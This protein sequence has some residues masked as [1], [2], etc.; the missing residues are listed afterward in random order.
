MQPLQKIFGLGL[1]YML[2]DTEFR[3]TEQ[4]LGP[5]IGQYAETIGDAIIKID[6]HLLFLVDTT[7]NMIQIETIDV[8]SLYKCNIIIGPDFR[9]IIV[10]HHFILLPHKHIL[11]T[12]IKYDIIKQEFYFDMFASNTQ[13]NKR[14]HALQKRYVPKIS[15]EVFE[16]MKNDIQNSTLLQEKIELIK[17]YIVW[18]CNESIDCDLLCIRLKI[19]KSIS[20]YLNDKPIID[21]TKLKGDRKDNVGINKESNCV[22]KDVY[23]FVMEKVKSIVAEKKIL[24]NKNYTVIATTINLLKNNIIHE[25]GSGDD[26]KHAES[27]LINIHHRNN[28]MMNGFKT[29]DII[30]VIRLYNNGTIGSGLPCQRCVKLIHMNGINHVVF[31]IDKNNYKILDMD[32]KTYTYTTT[33]NKLLHIDTYLYD[34]YVVHKACRRQREA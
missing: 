7:E 17:N 8:A 34:E 32:K 27:M 24:E 25:K 29:D 12:V 33:G 21:D 19:Q 18:T 30:F 16:M 3:K 31:S 23:R 15:D 28:D 26:N 20:C 14:I 9:A 22:N 13:Y 4:K 6:K 10:N 2:I 11:Y 1:S 5:V